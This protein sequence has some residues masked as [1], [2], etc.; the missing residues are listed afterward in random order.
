MTARL[1]PAFAALA[2]LALL[3]SWTMGVWAAACMGPPA[4]AVSIEQ[5]ADGHAMDHAAMSHGGMDHAAHHGHAGGG[6][7]GAPSPAPEGDRPGTPEPPC[8]V[9]L[10]GG[11][12][13]PLAFAAAPPSAPDPLPAAAY[14]PAADVAPLTLPISI[15]RP[16]ETLG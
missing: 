2:A 10:A 6:S 8:P 15:F 7:H 16:P 5:G 11:C 14:A 4:S 3:V 1:R 12:V 9:M 13:G